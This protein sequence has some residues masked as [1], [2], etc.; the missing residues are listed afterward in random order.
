MRNKDLV[1]LIAGCMGI[2]LGAFMIIEPLLPLPQYDELLEKQVTVSELWEHRVRGHSNYYIIS[3]LGN[4]RITGEYNWRELESTLVDGATA[5]VKYYPSK[6]LLFS[7]EMHAEEVVINGNWVVTFDNDKE[8]PWALHIIL[9]IV[10]CLGGI[11][12]IFLYRFSVIQD[13]KKQA[14][15]EARIIKKYGKLKK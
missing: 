7:D 4:Y 2:L 13:Q 10:F 14:K 8:P 1:F 11:A 5:I 15:R 9:C 3:D 12:F 6:H